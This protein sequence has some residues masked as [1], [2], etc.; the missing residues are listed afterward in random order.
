MSP[1]AATE[2][3]TEEEAADRN[4]PEDVQRLENQVPERLSVSD[5]LIL[6][7]PDVSPEQTLRHIVSSFSE[8]AAGQRRRRDFTD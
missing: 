3:L 2:T 8:T 6:D 5:V 4:Q 7:S 1:A